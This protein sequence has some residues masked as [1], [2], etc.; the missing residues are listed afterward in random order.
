LRE[1]EEVWP[2]ARG[3]RLRSLPPPEPPEMET[4][5]ELLA[6]EDVTVPAALMTAWPVTPAAEKAAAAATA[7]APVF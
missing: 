7:L 5:E 3:G 2:L 6:A 1:E 4:A